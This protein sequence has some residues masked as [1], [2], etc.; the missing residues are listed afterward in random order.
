VTES[1]EIQSGV[2]AGLFPGSYKPSGTTKTVLDTMASFLDFYK[3]PV[4][5]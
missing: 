3:N 5:M 1:N 4:K 2:K